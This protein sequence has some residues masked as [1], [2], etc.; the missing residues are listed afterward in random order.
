MLGQQPSTIWGKVSTEKLSLSKPLVHWGY[1]HRRWSIRYRRCCWALTNVQPQRFQVKI[2]VHKVNRFYGENV[3]SLHFPHGLND[4]LFINS[5]SNGFS[6]NLTPWIKRIDCPYKCLKTVCP[7]IL[8]NFWTSI[9]KIAVPF[10]EFKAPAS[11]SFLI[12]QPSP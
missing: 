5:V 9:Q 6:R 7:G 12:G 2:Q 3:P 1:Q 4:T 10:Q 11:F 8:F